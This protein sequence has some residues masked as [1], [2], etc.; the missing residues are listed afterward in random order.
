MFVIT[1]T[2]RLFKNNQLWGYRITDGQSTIDVNREQAWMYA[3]QKRVAN[4]T[5][6]GSG[7]NGDYGLS[8]T[9]GFELKSL[10]QIKWEEKLAKN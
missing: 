3:K 6:V 8:G 7:G 4:V 2:A 5:A 1:I 9:N 10:P